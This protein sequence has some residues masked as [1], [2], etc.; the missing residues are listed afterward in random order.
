MNPSPEHFLN[1]ELQALAF[2]RRVLAQAE[3]R[4]TP[5]LER[6]RFLCIVS[7]NLDEFFE[8]RVAGLK[9]QVKL[10]AGAADPDGLAPAEVFARVVPQARELVSRQYALLNGEILP[11]LEKQGIRF[12]R[13]AAWRP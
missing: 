2:N 4:A 5:L 12:L 6:L 10:G 3:D 13:R 9:E 7:S 8:I 1:R 11:A